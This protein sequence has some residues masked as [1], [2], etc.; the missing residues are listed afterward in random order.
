MISY[1]QYNIKINLAPL[2]FT[3]YAIGGLRACFISTVPLSIGSC[4]SRTSSSVQIR[5][6][7][8]AK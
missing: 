4:I 1:F 2:R 3:I 5:Y 7:T 8:I 6:V